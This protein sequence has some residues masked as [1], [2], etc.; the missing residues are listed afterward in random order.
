MDYFRFCHGA[1]LHQPVVQVRQL[2]RRNQLVAVELRPVKLRHHAGC[3]I[4]VHQS[5]AVRRYL[6]TFDVLRRLAVERRAL[7]RPGIASLAARVA[8]HLESVARCQ[9][10]YESVARRGHAVTYAVFPI[11]R[12][13]RAFSHGNIVEIKQLNGSGDELRIG[14]VRRH[15]IKSTV[16]R[17]P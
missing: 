15:C 13:R 7:P 3:R 8:R 5:L 14:R 16:V 6:E 10:G 12:H 4:F 9:G 1:R 2:H 17:N 11:E